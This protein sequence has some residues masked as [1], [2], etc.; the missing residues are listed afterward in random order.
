MHPNSHPSTPLQ[1]SRDDIVRA[2]KDVLETNRF[3]WPMIALSIG[4]TIGILAWNIEWSAALAAMMPIAVAMMR[5]RAQAFLVGMA[6]VFAAGRDRPEL[7]STWYESTIWT[8]VGFLAIVAVLGGLAWSLCWTAAKQPWRKALAVTIGWV[9]VLAPPIGLIA[10]GNPV[11]AWGYIAP[12]SGWLGVALSCLVPAALVSGLNTTWSQRKRPNIVVVAAAIALITL[13]A[14]HTPDQTKAA[15]SVRAISTEWGNAKTSSDVVERIEKM[16]QRLD[17]YTNDK[18]ASTLIYPE[19]GLMR[20]ESSWEP[21]IKVELTSKASKRQQ[22]VVIGADMTAANGTQQNVAIAIHPDGT[23]QAAVARLSV[24]VA[25]WHP[26]RPKDH[27]PLDLRAD[28][29]LELQDGT[30]ARVMFCYEEYFPI[31]SLINEALDPHELV[32]VMASLWFAEDSLA[33]A[34]QHRHI[35]GIAKLFGRPLVIAQNG[36]KRLKTVES[37]VTHIPF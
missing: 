20:Y 12:G 30:R 11:V 31:L 18:T 33:P 6:Y 16:G 22:T 32:V 24:P 27:F 29:I 35:E 17:D 8:G 14:V 1:P 23:R 28:N 15:G 7:I 36:P 4:Y 10:P 37:V 9:A 26:W 13:A 3:L 19:G 34:I 5:T 21:I 2:L 25:A